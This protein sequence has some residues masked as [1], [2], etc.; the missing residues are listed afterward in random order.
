MASNFLSRA[1]A[2]AHSVFNVGKPATEAEQHLR[3]VILVQSEAAKFD[4]WIDDSESLLE[5]EFAHECDPNLGRAVTNASEFA[6]L[7]KVTIMRLDPET[8]EAM[9]HW[10][11]A[12]VYAR[13][14]LERMAKE[15]R[16]EALTADAA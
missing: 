5:S 1:V 3:D 8:R 6:D 10:L 11:I 7:A 2:I 16:E 12:E 14:Q 13:N 4:A 15:S 9:A